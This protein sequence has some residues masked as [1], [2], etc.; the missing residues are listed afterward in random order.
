MF[1][2]LKLEQGSNLPLRHGGWGGGAR[3]VAER[4]TGVSFTNPLPEKK[5]N[6]AEMPALPPDGLTSAGLH[7]QEGG[8]R[9]GDKEMMRFPPNP[10]KKPGVKGGKSW[11]ATSVSM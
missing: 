2:D 9:E 6:P 5:T 8:R 3:G 7:R 1:V 4:L 10:P 11:R